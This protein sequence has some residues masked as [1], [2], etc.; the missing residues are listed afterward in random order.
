M[1]NLDENKFDSFVVDLHILCQFVFN[2][3]DF[4]A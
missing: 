2:F 4:F 3:L 1:Q